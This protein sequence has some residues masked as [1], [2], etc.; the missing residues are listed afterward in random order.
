VYAVYALEDPRYTDITRIRY[1]GLTKDVY[2]RFAQHVQ[3]SGGNLKK[4]SWV[5]ELKSLNIMFT[6][7]TVE[8]VETLDEARERE[9]YWMSRYFSL[10]AHL[11]NQYVPVGLISK[12]K[13]NDRV[14]LV[15]DNNKF[16]RQGELGTITYLVDHATDTSYVEF[17]NGYKFWVGDSILRP[18]CRLNSADDFLDD[19][20]I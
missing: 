5:Q 13:L 8:T 12:F 4:N 9:G 16:T 19:M 10:G 15:K 1:V 20:G 6:M 7:R 14:R 3:C 18:A 11:F 17:D 2:T